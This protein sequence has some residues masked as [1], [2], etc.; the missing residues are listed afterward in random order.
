MSC[1][2]CITHQNPET[3]SMQTSSSNLPSC[4]WFQLLIALDTKLDKAVSS[5]EFN[6][7]DLLHAC[8]YKI[9]ILFVS[10]RCIWC[11]LKIDGLSYQLLF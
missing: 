9:L 1:M 11:F 7:D 8:L 2:Q 4:D 10:R 6:F 3:V 5:I